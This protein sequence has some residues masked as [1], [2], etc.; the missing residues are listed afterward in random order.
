MIKNNN[1]IMN[2]VTNGS[3]RMG[4]VINRDDTLQSTEILCY[5]KIIFSR[6]NMVPPDC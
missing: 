2:G 4:L 5:G 1:H 3:T 6:G